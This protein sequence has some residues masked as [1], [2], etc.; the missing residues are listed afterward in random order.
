MNKLLKVLL[1]T[2]LAIVLVSCGS[3]S[4]EEAAKESKLE[5]QIVVKEGAFYAITQ[6]IEI[7]E[8]GLKEM[9]LLNIS[10]DVEYSGVICEELQ[11]LVEVDYLLFTSENPIENSESIYKVIEGEIL[12]EGKH[13]PGIL[14][15]SINNDTGEFIGELSFD[16]KENRI[17][18]YIKKARI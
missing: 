6:N 2:S 10:C 4:S 8:N 14:R 13:F 1:V 17:V 11:N 18:I 16:L 7:N 15:Y 5:N 3:N 12:L 9:T